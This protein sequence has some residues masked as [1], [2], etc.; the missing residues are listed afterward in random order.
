[1]NMNKYHIQ[2]DG[3]RTSPELEN[4]MDFIIIVDAISFPFED[5]STVD[6]WN[7]C[8][9]RIKEREVVEKWK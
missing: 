6:E 2:I 1:M 8:L 3:D 5:C 7:A 4:E 9:E